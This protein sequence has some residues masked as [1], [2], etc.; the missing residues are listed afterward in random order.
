MAALQSDD[1]VL[2]DASE[3]EEV[4]QIPTLNKYQLEEGMTADEA[5]TLKEK[6]EKKMKKAEELRQKNLN[7][8]V[9]KAQ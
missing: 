3:T 9:Q 5:L 6:T 4:Q 2:T 7:R 8:K 1:S